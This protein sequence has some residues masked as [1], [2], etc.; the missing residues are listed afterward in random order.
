[1]LRRPEREADE[2]AAI[3]AGEV[4]ALGFWLVAAR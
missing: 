1:M 3:A 2:L 4:P